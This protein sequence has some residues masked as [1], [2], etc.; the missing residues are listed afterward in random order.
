MERKLLYGV[1]VVLSIALS[2]VSG[3]AIAS[4]KNTENLSNDLPYN[5]DLQNADLNFSETGNN[6]NTINV[7][8][9]GI[10]EGKPDSVEMEIGV[11]TEVSKDVGADE[12]TE[13]NSS[14]INEVIESLKEEGVEEEDIETSRYNLS[15]QREYKDRGEDRREITGYRVVHTLSIETSDT[16]KAGKLIDIAVDSGAN[17]VGGI[18]FIFS[19][20]KAGEIET[21]ARGKAAEDARDKAEVIADSLGVEIIG[22][23]EV[24]EGYQTYP[25]YDGIDA[26][27]DRSTSI[28]APDSLEKRISLDVVFVIG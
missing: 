17:E 9:T 5:S 18:Q 8:G 3:Y 4:G 15:V 19:E 11:I 23:S 1:I 25:R 2:G 20:E 14:S 13:R 7:T 16:E 28:A 12:A 24:T 6:L 21:N 22:V 27:E 26:A 10:A